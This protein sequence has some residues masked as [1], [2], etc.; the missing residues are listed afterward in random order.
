MSRFPCDVSGPGEGKTTASALR[1]YTNAATIGFD[2]FFDECEPHTAAFLLVAR[3]QGLEHA[4]YPLLKFGGN[5]WAVIGHTEF[6]KM[7]VY[8]L[9]LKANHTLVAIVMFNRIGK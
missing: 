4:K 7:R 9:R 8:L 3:A 2:Q 6:V 1:K 5:A